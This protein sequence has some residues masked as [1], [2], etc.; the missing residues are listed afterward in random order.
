MTV[1]GVLS[2]FRKRGEMSPH[3]RKVKY[4]QFSVLNFG[5]A[6]DSTRG[7]R[8]A[9]CGHPAAIL[10]HSDGQLERLDSTCTVQWLGL[11]CRGAPALPGRYSRAVYRRSNRI[12]QRR[13]RRVWKKRLVEALRQYHEL[14]TQALLASLADE[15]RQFSPQEQTDD[16]TLIV[17]KCRELTTALRP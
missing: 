17:A 4:G 11:R 8:Y 16:I 2:S 10:L 14:P 13:R 7:L 5:A 15:V 6:F 3:E 12:V 1:I 9:N